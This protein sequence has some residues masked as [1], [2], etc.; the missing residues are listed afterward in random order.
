MKSERAAANCG[1][2]YVPDGPDRQK[3]APVKGPSSNCL[4]VVMVAMFDD[5][6]ACKTPR[7]AQH[8]FIEQERSVELARKGVVEVLLD[9][10]TSADR[11]DN[12]PDGR[13]R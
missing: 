10:R 5:N 1:S 2:F 8:L 9:R 13:C 7:F 12:C 3:T 4:I 11:R 6:D